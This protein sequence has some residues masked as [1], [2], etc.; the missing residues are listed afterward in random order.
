[1]EDLK[2]LL[3]VLENSGTLN[4]AEKKTIKDKY[5]SVFGRQLQSQKGCKNCWHDALIELITALKGNKYGMRAGDIIRY[6]GHIYGRKT[7]TDDI[8]KAYL[9]ENP[10]EKNKIYELH[11]TIISN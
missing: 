5:K 7:I 1:M 6:E 10:N 2:A 3:S 9:K 11:R 4:A 8:A